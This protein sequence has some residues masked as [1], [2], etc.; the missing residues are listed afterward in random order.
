M[1]GYGCLLRCAHLFLFK[2]GSAVQAHAMVGGRSCGGFSFD[3]S[4]PAAGLLG[5]GSGYR[6]HNHRRDRSRQRCGASIAV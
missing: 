1:F 4:V 6:D 5:F 3:L 2:E